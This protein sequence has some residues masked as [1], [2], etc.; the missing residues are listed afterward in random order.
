MVNVIIIQWGF[1]PSEISIFD[2]E[3][4]PGSLDGQDTRDGIRTLGLMWKDQGPGC[5]VKGA[6]NH[7]PGYM[8]WS[9]TKVDVQPEKS[10]HKCWT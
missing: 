3:L 6:D 2:G 8:D 4:P 7:D 10:Q 9:C 5:Y 1:P